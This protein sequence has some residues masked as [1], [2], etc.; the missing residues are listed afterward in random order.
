MTEAIKATFLLFKMIN[1]MQVSCLSE[2]RLLIFCQRKSTD[3]SCGASL[4]T[5]FATA[6]GRV[7]NRAAQDPRK[8]QVSVMYYFYIETNR[9]KGRDLHALP[10]GICDSGACEAVR[11]YSMQQQ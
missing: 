1:A 5:L 3:T 7:V 10:R 2:L 6:A 11:G 8:P 4:T 9:E